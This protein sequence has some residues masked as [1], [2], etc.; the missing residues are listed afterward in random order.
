MNK[1]L[2]S[3][4]RRKKE[5]MLEMNPHLKVRRKFVTSTKLMRD[6]HRG[7]KDCYRSLAI[8][9]SEINDFPSASHSDQPESNQSGEHHASTADCYHLGNTKLIN[10]LNSMDKIAFALQFHQRALDI[11]LELLG[12]EHSCTA[13]SYYFLANTQHEMNY[14]TSALESH[15]RFLDI[16]RKLFGGNYEGTSDNYCSLGIVQCEM[17][18]FTL[19]LRSHQHALDIRLKLFGEDHASTADCHYSMGNTSVR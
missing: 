19:A 13:D 9:Q 16:R 17:G 7:S 12:E 15:L 8:T 4:A 2:Q 18:D 1:L 5:E 11:C 6:E 14:F 3:F 10:T